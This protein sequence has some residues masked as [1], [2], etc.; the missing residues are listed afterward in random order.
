MKLAECLEM[1]TEEMVMIR[2]REILGEIAP[3]EERDPLMV[4][5]TCVNVV[6]LK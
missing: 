1:D 2:E 3:Q 6:S 5:K 4:F